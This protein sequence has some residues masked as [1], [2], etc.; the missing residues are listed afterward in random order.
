M[1]MSSYMSVA[2]MMVAH[3]PMTRQVR[4]LAIDDQLLKQC[5]DAFLQ[6]VL[7]V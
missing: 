7:F 4:N 6:P 2:Y 3:K 5:A 1:E